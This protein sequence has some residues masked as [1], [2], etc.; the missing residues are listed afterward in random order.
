MVWE[1]VGREDSANVKHRVLH[2][3]VSLVGGE[4]E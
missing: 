1:V 3:Q 4:M 2:E